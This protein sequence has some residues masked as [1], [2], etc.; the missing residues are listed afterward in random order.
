MNS[1]MPICDGW[2]PIPRQASRRASARREC[3]TGDYFHIMAITGH[4]TLRAL[5]RY[6]LIDEGDLQDAM[7]TLQTFLSHHA[8]D[9]STGTP[10]P[11]RPSYLGGRVL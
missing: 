4:K 1:L 2:L 6:N 3:P 7:A 11:Q 9:T 8:L 10:A 5:Q